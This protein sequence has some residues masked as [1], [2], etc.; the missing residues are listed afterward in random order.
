MTSLKGPPGSLRWKHTALCPVLTQG[1][2]STPRPQVGDKR[3]GLLY[4]TPVASGD[5]P[6]NPPPLGCGQL[7]VAGLCLGMPPPGWTELGVSRCA[8]DPGSMLMDRRRFC[9]G[10]STQP[11]CSPCDPRRRPHCR[12]QRH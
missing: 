7:W 4:C 6:R 8:E 10:G 1:D 12:D 5:L 2:S 11:T 9:F 3:K